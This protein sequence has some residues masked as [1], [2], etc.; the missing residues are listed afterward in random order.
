MADLIY[1]KALEAFLTG[2]LDPLTGNVKAALVNTAHYTVDGA[3]HQFLTAL[4]ADA[5]AVVST[6]PNLAS[7]TY[8]G[9]VFDAADTLLPAVTGAACQALVL[10]VDTGTPATSRLLCYLEPTAPLTPDGSDILL[11]WPALGI[12][13]L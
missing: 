10:Y 13:A 7:K 2:A 1:D 3:A 11:R 6:S 4:T 5:L 8:A 12:F 9:G